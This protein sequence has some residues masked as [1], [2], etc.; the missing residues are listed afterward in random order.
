MEAKAFI[1]HTAWITCGL[2]IFILTSFVSVSLALLSS[3]ESTLTFSK[4]HQDKNTLSR[5]IRLHNQQN[6]DKPITNKGG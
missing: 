4:R 2:S 1:S 3:N 6:I 5:T